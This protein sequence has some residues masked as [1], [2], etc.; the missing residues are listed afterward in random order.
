[1]SAAATVGLPATRRPGRRAGAG[2]AAAAALA[3]LAGTLGV[4]SL[5]AGGGTDGGGAEAP[6]VAPR[7]SLDDVRQRGTAVTLPSGPAVVNFFAAWCEPCREELP[8]LEQAHRRSGGSVRFVGI[9]VSDSRSRA[10]ELLDQAGV[11][12]PAGYDP[13][14]AVAADYRLRGM[15]TTVFVDAEGRMAE[16]SRGR[17]TADELDARLARLAPTGGVGRE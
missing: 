15:P 4:V 3:V 10:A 2:V 12:F 8:L 11:S 1:M 14:G 6:A 13:D 16:V 17:L 9:D 7:F 5:R